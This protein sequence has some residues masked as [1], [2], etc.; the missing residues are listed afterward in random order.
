MV[1]K[2]TL[3]NIKIIL[4]IIFSLNINIYN[5]GMEKV[6]TIKCIFLGDSIVGKTQI[7]NCINEQNFSENYLAT[8][9]ADTTTKLYSFKSNINNNKFKSDIIQYKFL[10]TSGLELFRNYIREYFAEQDVL[11]LVY[12]ITNRNSFKNV[13]IH[14]TDFM[15][16]VKSKT[17]ISI[18]IGNKKEKKKNR[19]V[20]YLEGKTFAK[21]NNIN[22]F[23]EV[24]AKTRSGIQNLESLLKKD[25]L[26]KLN[27]DLLINKTTMKE[28]IKKDIILNNSNKNVQKSEIN[29]RCN[30]F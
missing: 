13:S 11:L 7:I 25:I 10:D 30:I 17:Y 6:T 14:L 3:V 19:S 8:I 4:I 26:I 23:F 12:D 22:Y 16:Q 18:L 9:I 21:Y 20:S 1:F 15:E 5:L 28:H 2:L 27:K 24:S 29:T